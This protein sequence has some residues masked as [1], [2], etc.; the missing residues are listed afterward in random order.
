[1]QTWSSFFE[2]PIAIAFDNF[3][4]WTAG[5]II[6]KDVF[7]GYSIV[8]RNA[9]LDVLND[10]YQMFEI[11]DVNQPIFP[12]FVQGPIRKFLRFM[13]STWNYFIAYT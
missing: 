7:V 9:K 5:I 6:E 11:V 1:M 2:C 13:N 8:I 4:M 10:M 3:I 12:S